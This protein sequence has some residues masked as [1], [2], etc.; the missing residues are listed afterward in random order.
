MKTQLN[1][2]VSLLVLLVT[3]SLPL[4]AQDG[5]G[6]PLA[7]TPIDGGLTLLVA[8]GIGYGAK[9]IKDNKRNK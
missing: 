9:K 2:V 5:F 1:K 6:D 3:I 7:D 8:A 4:L